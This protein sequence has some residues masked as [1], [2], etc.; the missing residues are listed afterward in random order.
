MLKKKEKKCQQISINY[1]YG[2]STLLR[3]SPTSELELLINKLPYVHFAIPKSSD[4]S[5][6]LI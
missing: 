3:K 2:K 6:S 1:Q 5:L 4:V